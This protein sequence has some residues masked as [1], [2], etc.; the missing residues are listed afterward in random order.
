MDDFRLPLHAAVDL[1]A[2]SALPIGPTPSSSN[3]VR[4]TT[5][6]PDVSSVRTLRGKAMM[7]SGGVVYES[8][9]IRAIG[10]IVSL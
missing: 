4:P 5:V 8:T 3:A 2:L 9:P 10:L 1:H 6:Q 7:A